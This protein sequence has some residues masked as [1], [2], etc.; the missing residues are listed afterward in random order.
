MKQIINPKMKKI[1]N[2]F[3]IRTF[4]MMIQFTIV[5]KIYRNNKSKVYILVIKGTLL[6]TNK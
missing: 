6:I 2:K 1:R 4:Y 3:K 5:N